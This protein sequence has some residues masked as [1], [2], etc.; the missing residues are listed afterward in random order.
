MQHLDIKHLIH[1][2]MIQNLCEFPLVGR[3]YKESIQD[4]D[5]KHIKH[6][7]KNELEIM[8]NF[9]GSVIIAYHYALQDALREQG[10]ALPDFLPPEFSRPSGQEDQ[11]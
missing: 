10:I 9:V 6:N 2:A 3:I 5:Y 8:H 4:D 7:L 11:S 1:K